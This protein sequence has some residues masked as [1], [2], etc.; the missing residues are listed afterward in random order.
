V[1]IA[2]NT[3]L[4]KGIFIERMTEDDFFDLCQ[5]NETLNF[6]RDE[7]GNIL[8]TP[9]MGSLSSVY[10]GNIAHQLK[11]WNIK[12]KLGVV[13]GSNGGVMIIN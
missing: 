7:N 9:I 4:I 3:C 2:E 5:A 12:N 10:N 6:E 13:L 11:S 1:Y 8:L